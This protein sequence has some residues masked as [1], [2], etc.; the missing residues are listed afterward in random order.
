[1]IEIISIALIIVGIL[2]FLFGLFMMKT[3]KLKPIM[4][5]NNGRYAILIPARD[6]SKVIDG[7]LTSIDNQTRKINS[8]DVYV[9]VESMSDKT[10]EITKK[11]NM[12][13][14]LRCDL[15]KKRKGYALDDAVKEILSKNIKYEA[16]FIFDADNILD[17]NYIKEMEKSINKGYDIGIGYRNTKNSDNLVSAASSLTFSMVN[18]IANEMKVKYH[19][20][21]TISGTG[22]YIRGYL[23]EKWGGFIFH[24]LTEDYEFTLYS[25]FNDLTSTYNKKAIFFDEQPESF[26]VSIKQRARWARGYFQAR[27]KYISTMYNENIIKGPN[28]SSKINEFIGIKPLISILIGILIILI[29]ALI[30]KPFNTFIKY[31]IIMLL[32]SYLVL[33][34]FTLIMVIK[35]KNHLNMSSKMRIKVIFYNPIFL[36]SYLICVVLL[37]FDR[38]LGW[39]K[40]EH[41]K[42]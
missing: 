27:C 21:L 23:I 37:L 10:V 32:S 6:E 20:S 11:H 39:D 7:L 16:Y 36:A 25:T 38:N 17:K 14:V 5:N 30:T 22:Y 19:N 3:N 31:L 33:F 2:S 35:E 40:I 18:T 12:N 15:T 24:T 26:I 29:N 28:S 4:R 42:N 8:K 34:V 9:I 13:V 41:N 1:M